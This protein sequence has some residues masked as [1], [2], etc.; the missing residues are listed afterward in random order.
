MKILDYKACTSLLIYNSGTQIQG[1][2][3]TTLSLT[4]KKRRELFKKL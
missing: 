1:E 3:S 4:H 2:E